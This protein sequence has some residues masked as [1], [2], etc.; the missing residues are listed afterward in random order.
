VLPPLPTSLV[1][2][3]CGRNELTVLPEFHPGLRRLWV[4][5]NPWIPAFRTCI[6]THFGDAKAATRMFYAAQRAKNLVTFRLT[7]EPLFPADV[8]SVI[9]SFIS[10][11]GSSGSSGSSGFSVSPG[12]SG[13]PGSVDQQFAQLRST[14]NQHGPANM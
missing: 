7:V 2:F 11:F 6:V 1:E 12:F 9:A 5:R 8:A 10:G 13:S 4:H 14:T 3:W